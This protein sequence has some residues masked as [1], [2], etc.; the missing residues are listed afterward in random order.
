MYRRFLAYDLGEIDPSLN[1]TRNEGERRLMHV[2][3]ALI[4][5]TMSVGLANLCDPDA[6]DGLGNFLLGASAAQVDKQRL[7]QSIFDEESKTKP[8]CVL[9]GHRMKA[10]TVEE[11]DMLSDYDRASCIPIRKSD[12]VVLP[13]RLEDTPLFN[14]K[15]ILTFKRF[16]KAHT[17]KMIIEKLS[18]TK[19]GFDFYSTTNFNTRGMRAEI[20]PETIEQLFE[21]GDIETDPSLRFKSPISEAE[22]PEYIKYRLAAHAQLRLRLHTLI[23]AAAPAPACRPLAFE[24]ARYYLLRDVEKYRRPRMMVKCYVHGSS[25]KCLCSAHQLKSMEERFPNDTFTGKSQITISYE[26]CGEALHNGKCPIHQD[27]TNFHPHCQNTCCACCEISMTCRHER[28]HRGKNEYVDSVKIHCDRLD[29]Y[30]FVEATTIMGYLSK[31]IRQFKRINKMELSPKDKMNKLRDTIYCVERLLEQTLD[32]IEREEERE[33]PLYDK[34]ELVRMDAL[35]VRLLTSGGVIQ[36]SQ[37]PDRN[38]RLTRKEWGSELTA[39]EKSLHKFPHFRFFPKSLRDA[40]RPLRTD[41]FDSMLHPKGVNEI[42][43]ANAP[44]EM[45]DIPQV[46]RPRTP[47]A[48]ETPNEAN[49]STSRNDSPCNVEMTEFIDVE[50][51][52]VMSMTLSEL[53]ESMTIT[54]KEREKAHFMLHYLQAFDDESGSAMTGPLG[55]SVKP[56]TCRYKNRHEGGRL[57]AIGK[58]VATTYKNGE[59]RTVAVQSANREIR[60]YLCGRFARDFDLANCQPEILRQMNGQL[61]WADG[62][63]PSEMPQLNSWCSNRQ[64]FIDHVAEV[65]SLPSDDVRWPDFR[66]DTVKQLM[67]RLMFGGTYDAWIRDIGGDPALPIKSPLVTRLAKELAKLRDD[68]FASDQWKDFVARDLERLQR[69]AKKETQDEMDRSTFARIAQSEENR[70]LTVMRN[71]I[72]RQGFQV[73]TLCFDGLMVIERPGHALDLTALNAEILRKTGYAL[74][75]VEKPLFNDSDWPDLQLAR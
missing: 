4:D 75:V 15:V 19:I 6:R 44:P 10:L 69:E 52:E 60:W 68:V 39:E 63:K 66:K 20:Q 2:R 17:P 67:I 49:G 30:T 31:Y 61:T 74:Q 25:C 64:Q 41:S 3:S 23:T 16:A 5:A 38:P 42:D 65:H 48:A 35:A 32:E 27:K 21:F 50:G 43:L 12:M 26:M 11:A 7:L 29:R 36:M 70:V 13:S 72:T 9:A 73:M 55:R 51:L 45:L 22:V 34:V 33:K 46:K 40:K 1:D 18:N 62:R 53:M 37:G 8:A 14:H 24:N 56:L 54:D 28:V 59:A 58:S 71:F 47:K 57:Y